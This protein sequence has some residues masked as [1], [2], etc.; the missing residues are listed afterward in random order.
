M[1]LIIAVYFLTESLG[2][3]RKTSV[4]TVMA[5]VTFMA[6]AKKNCGELVTLK[7]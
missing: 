6:M 3:G 4:M 2:L 7:T 5:I 1:N